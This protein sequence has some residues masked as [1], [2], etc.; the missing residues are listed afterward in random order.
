[1]GSVLKKLRKQSL[2]IEQK[3]ETLQKHISQTGETIDVRDL[4]REKTQESLKLYRD[5]R[6]KR[7][8]LK[9]K[10]NA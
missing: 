2:K 1:M 9:R 7:K 4:L 3:I 8:A 5:T 10:L 6:N